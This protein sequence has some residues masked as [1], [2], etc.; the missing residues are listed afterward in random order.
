MLFLYTFPN[1]LSNK[2]PAKTSTPGLCAHHETLFPLLESLH[3]PASPTTSSFRSPSPSVIGL[4]LRSATIH[5][6]VHCPL[7]STLKS[8]VLNTHFSFSG[9][10]AYHTH[11]GSWSWRPI[12]VASCWGLRE[13]FFLKVAS[14]KREDH[15][16][17]G[18][19]ATG[20]VV[21]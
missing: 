5:P 21:V 20:G 8:S 9:H 11:S 7:V 16:T 2:C 4:P 17:M 10:D 1:T 15:S 19:P 12:L 3:P 14:R 6:L 18:D 13:R